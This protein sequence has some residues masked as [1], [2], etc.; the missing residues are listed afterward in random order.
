MP[1]TS[2]AI[3][4]HHY[5][6]SPFSH[7]ARMLLGLKDA[8]WFS[9]QTPNMMPKPDLVP[10]TG[11]YRRAPVMQIG[12]DVYCDSQLIM[13]E[14]DR[15][16]PSTA[17]DAGN[18]WMVNHWADRAM[19]EP[20]VAIIFGGLGEKV[21]PAFIADREKLTGRPFD[22]AAMAKAAL[23]AQAQWRAMAGWI[24][25]A[26]AASRDGYLNGTEPG[27][28][29]LAA[30]MNIWFLA[31]TFPDLAQALTGGFEKLARWRRDMEAI[32]EGERTEISGSDALQIATD[33]QPGET[34]VA[35]DDASCPG[36]APGDPV[37]AMATDY[38]RDP[39]RGT[40]VAADAQRMVIARMDDALGALHL[41]FPRVGYL[42]LPDERRQ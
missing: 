38:G 28:A 29:D 41:H 9:V 8:H 19:F 32:G 37:I 40:L 1:A 6:A 42:L 39:V 7:K 31:N 4:L 25:E 20:T 5:D 14:I 27:I 11:G 18:A 10:L 22:I 26:L 13:A 34:P 2:T 15:R 17:S 33:S 35:H 3:I 23:P 12:A 16:L 24:D 30:F 36:L 21:D